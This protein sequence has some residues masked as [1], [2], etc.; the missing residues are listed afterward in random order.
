MSQA[1]ADRAWAHPD[2]AVLVR[3]GPCVPSLVDVLRLSAFMIDDDMILLTGVA[4]QIIKMRPYF[5]MEISPIGHLLAEW[6]T[7]TKL[8]ARVCEVCMTHI[9]SGYSRSEELNSSM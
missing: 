8:C 5:L 4:M 2:W 6:A 1:S 9:L 3:K 7:T